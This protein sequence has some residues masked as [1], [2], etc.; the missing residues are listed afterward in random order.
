GIKEQMMA[1]G[2]SAQDI[3]VVFTHVSMKTIIVPPPE[4]DKP[5]VFL[6]VGRLKFEGQKRDKDLFDG[7]ARTTGEWQLPH[8]GDGS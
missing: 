8:L 1:R 5:A 7:L 4:R 3:R 6:Y 2:L